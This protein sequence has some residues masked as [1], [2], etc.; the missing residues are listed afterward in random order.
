MS[1]FLNGASPTRQAMERES[2]IEAGPA[3][4]R[5]ADLDDG[6]L[7]DPFDIARTKNASIERLRRWRVRFLSSD[8][9]SY[10][11]MLLFCFTSACALVFLLHV[12]M[13]LNCLSHLILL[14]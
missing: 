14:W 8:L 2:D 3:S 10:F 7:S 5:S 11:L 9:Y 6:D 4:L 13:F 1:S 12:S